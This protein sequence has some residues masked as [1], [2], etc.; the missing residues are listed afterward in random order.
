MSRSTAQS[1]CRCR[2][3]SRRLLTDL[4]DPAFVATHALTSKHLLSQGNPA[5]VT[6]T[7]QLYEATPQA[8]LLRV[9]TDSLDQPFDLN[10]G[11]K[12]G[13]GSTAKLR[14]LAHYLEVVAQLHAELT[15]RGHPPSSRLARDPISE[16]ALQIIE[17]DPSIGLEAFLQQALEREY[18]AEARP[19]GLSGQQP[20]RHQRARHQR[21]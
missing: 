2:A 9:Q 20:D 17:S 5:D 11:M 21:D 14:T 15:G 13:L 7:V 19:G 18:P 12:M 6:Y 10:T 3:P 4:R 1:T 8:N 16:W